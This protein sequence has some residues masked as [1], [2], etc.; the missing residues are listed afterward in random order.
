M[1]VEKSFSYPFEDKDWLSK[2]GLGAVIS[3]VP[4]LNFAWYGYL[5]DIIRNVM[6]QAAEP[7]PTWDDLSQKFNE[8]LILFAAGLI[9]ASP[10][11]I[12]VCLP[13]TMILSSSLFSE[14]THTQDIGETLLQA[15]GA[16]LYCL[17]CVLLLYGLVLSILYPALLILFAREGTFASCFKLREAFEMIRKNAAPFFI[18]WALS[19]AASLG[20]GLIVGFVNLVVS[21]IPCIGWI[22]GLALGLASAA[23]STAVYA[24]LFGQVGRIAFERNQLASGSPAAP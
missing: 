22:V 13:L 5:V 12:A 18:A 9:Y 14:N 19:I 24:H 11:L 8:G 23:Y 1:N 3:M 10:I 20:V 6:H 17:L 4:I 21:W 16:L 7:L 15:G 2:L